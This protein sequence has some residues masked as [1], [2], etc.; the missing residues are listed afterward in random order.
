MKIKVILSV[1]FLGFILPLTSPLWSSA[2][3]LPLDHIL[4]KRISVG[5]LEN[6]DQRHVVGEKIAL[7]FENSGKTQETLTIIRNLCRAIE[8]TRR[9]PVRT[10][11]DY[12]VARGFM[13][14]ENVS[15]L[16]PIYINALKIL[17]EVQDSAKSGPLHLTDFSLDGCFKSPFFLKFIFGELGLKS[18][19]S[20]YLLP[21]CFCE[22]QTSKQHE[23]ENFAKDFI[24]AAYTF[25]M[26]LGSLSVAGIKDIVEWWYFTCE[27]QLLG[28]GLKEPSASLDTLKSSL[29]FSC[30]A[31]YFKNL[32]QTSRFLC[33]ET[34]S[35]IC[36]VF[37]NTIQNFHDHALPLISMIDQITRV[38]KDPS[39][40]KSS[41]P[42]PP[43]D[44]ESFFE[45]YEMAHLMISLGSTHSLTKIRQTLNID[46]GAEVSFSTEN[47]QYVLNKIEFTS[48]EGEFLSFS[49]TT[50][51]S[52]SRLLRK[53]PLVSLQSYEVQIEN[54]L[55][56]KLCQM[57]DERDDLQEKTTK[58][59]DDLKKQISTLT[60]EVLKLQ[61]QIKKPQKKEKK[62]SPNKELQEEKAYAL[63]LSSQLEEIREDLNKKELVIREKNTMIETQRKDL[64]SLNEGILTFRKENSDHLRDL[65]EKDK[66]IVALRQELDS[67]KD[68]PDRASAGDLSKVPRERANFEARLLQFQKDLQTHQSELK[69]KISELQAMEKDRDAQAQLL[70]KKTVDFIALEKE[71]GTALNQAAALRETLEEKDRSVAA[72]KLTSPSK[73]SSE[74]T[75]EKRLEK[76]E[77]H[78]LETSPP[79]S[80]TTGSPPTPLRA[81]V[82]L[83]LRPTQPQELSSQR[84]NGS[85][86][87]GEQGRQGSS[88]DFRFHPP[89]P[90][91]FTPHQPYDMS[92]PYPM[93]QPYHPS[94][95]P[96]FFSEGSFPT[97][98]YMMIPDG[99][100]M[101]PNGYMARC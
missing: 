99:Y 25:E 39:T 85:Q 27:D 96:M 56:P 24:K 6:K 67:K 65:K 3:D 35:G 87:R 9:P 62:A 73:V 46:M 11:E 28:E 16:Q 54:P 44:W 82:P 1:I 31:H 8:G 86:T 47:D 48:R 89:F 69:A 78:L 98:G 14:K 20:T 45:S 68:K 101:M 90:P 42:L 19:P 17:G 43:K 29:D 26:Q 33:L 53:N 32:E 66:T 5:P 81:I 74:A 64:M 13:T 91:A 51:P 34:T 92:Q 37:L 12:V 72:Q 76:I 59:R 63:R 80:E 15:I 88:N 10:F 36:R 18:F 21:F 95:G 41:S 52:L 61:E 4:T 97:D 71:L 22:W 57:T 100:V 83:E 70:Q 93:M 2:S 23:V 94:Y 75:L 50:W 7:F 30:S 38:I 40:L 60:G 58:E 79:S 55:A 84:G 77:K 49:Q